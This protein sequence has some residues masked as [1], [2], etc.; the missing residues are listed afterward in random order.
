MSEAQRTN[1]LYKNGITLAD[2][3]KA[4]KDSYVTGFHEGGRLAYRCAL[5]AL[6]LA[7]KTVYG[8][9]KKRAARLMHEFDR[10][11]LLCINDE[12]MREDVWSKLGIEINWDDPLDRIEEKE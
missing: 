4:S 11:I 12:T 3:E 5:C 9:G 7:S 10:E 2:V 1:A 6:A 8:F